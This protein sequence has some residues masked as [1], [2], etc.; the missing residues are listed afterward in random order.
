MLAKP[1]PVGIE[2]IRGRSRQEFS[3]L[4]TITAVATSD[5]CTP[6]VALLCKA[7]VKKKKKG[8]KNS[9][10]ALVRTLMATGQ[11]KTRRST[12]DNVYNLHYGEGHWVMDGWMI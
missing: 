1:F 5:S 9:G 2:W 8:K 4:T 10:W 12:T 11:V 6:Y 3:C 7:K